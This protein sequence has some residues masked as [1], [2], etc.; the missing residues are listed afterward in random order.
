MD[1]RPV[2][3]RLATPADDAPLLALDRDCTEPGTGF[4]SVHA[5]PADSFFAGS[6]PADTVVAEVGGRVV[7]YV[8]LASPT[9]LPEN[10][11][12]AQIQGL[13]VRPT[14]R[15]QGIGRRLLLQAEQQTR[16]AGRR[17]LSLRV[18]STNARARALYASCGF[19]VEGVLVDE[20]RIDG[21]WVDDI[22]MARAL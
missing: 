21:A 17:K 11:H 18:L 1:G 15:G 9:S 12:V 5:R 20:F 13:A 6:D 8:T 14:L 22:L 4:P 7:G 16:D 2:T 10:T 3:F 19:V